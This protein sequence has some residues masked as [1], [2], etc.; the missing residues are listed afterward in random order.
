MNKKILFIFTLAAVSSF[1]A[2]AN[3]GTGGF[4]S[5]AIETLN[6]IEKFFLDDT[7]NL[8]DRF[9]AWLFE[10]YVKAQLWA[11]YQTIKFVWPIAKQLIENFNFGTILNNQLAAL[12]NDL[13]VA[14][15]IMQIPNS[16]NFLLNAYLTKFIINFIRK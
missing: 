1:S 10:W 11:E 16:L 15:N 2:L 13:R 7:P 5:D 9:F 6:S 4:F 12:P 3:D 8:I 14:I